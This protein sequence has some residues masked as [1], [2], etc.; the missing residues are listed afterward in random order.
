MDIADNSNTQLTTNHQIVRDLSDKSD[1]LIYSL[2]S[3]KFTILLQNYL[4]SSNFSLEMEHVYS[5]GQICDTAHEMFLN[6]VLTKLKFVVLNLTW[7]ST[8]SL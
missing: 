5:L 1:D 4:L 6:V 7:E 3:N 2:T 8:I